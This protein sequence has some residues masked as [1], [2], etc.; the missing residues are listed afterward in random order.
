MHL[1]E[2]QTKS[3]SKV[4]RENQGRMEIP[5]SVDGRTDERKSK[6]VVNRYWSQ[7]LLWTEITRSTLQEMC[8]QTVLNEKQVGP[9]PNRNREKYTYMQNRKKVFD[10]AGKQGEKAYMSWVDS[11]LEE[12][13]KWKRKRYK[14]LIRNHL[15]IYMSKVCTI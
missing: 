14:Y 8:Q 2:T 7:K 6:E 10:D 13:Y 11:F 12:L 1:N 15:G 9:S 5:K 4:Q 3:S